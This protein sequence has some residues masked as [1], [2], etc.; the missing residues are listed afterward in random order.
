MIAA[1]VFALL[2][3]LIGAAPA[4]DDSTGC[5]LA[6][7]DATP[8]QVA[9]RLAQLGVV[10]WGCEESTVVTATWTRPTEGSPVVYYRIEIEMVGAWPD[11]TVKI[12]VPV[13]ADSLRGRVAGVDAQGRQGPWSEWNEW[14]PINR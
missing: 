6:L 11:T 10:R 8:L 5:P 14:Y 1:M 7:R 4:A 12:P 13:W 9:M 3:P 2:Y